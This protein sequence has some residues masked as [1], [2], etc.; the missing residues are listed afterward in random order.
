MNILTGMIIENVL[1]HSAQDDDSMMFS[2][3]EAHKD[4]IEDAKRIFQNLD[5]NV[6]G[7]IG[8]DEFHAGM[9]HTNVKALMNTIDLQVKDAEW[10]FKVLLD[11]SQTDTVDI[12]HFVSACM[13][14][15]GAA[16]SVDLQCLSIQTQMI[17]QKVQTVL[18]HLALF[19]T[20]PQGTR[21]IHQKVQT[22]LN[23]L[24]L[25]PTKPQGTLTGAKS[26]ITL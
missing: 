5:S 11:I 24:A 20:K 18:N 7:T 22:V 17:H 8:L 1:K 13:K 23:H 25:P 2:Y 9:H 6:D 15:K 10:F 19:P 12:G 16:T 4:A 26:I 3:R 21:M 14:M